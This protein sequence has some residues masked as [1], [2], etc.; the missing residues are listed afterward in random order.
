MPV[1]SLRVRLYFLMNFDLEHSEV[2]QVTRG[3]YRK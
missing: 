1:D 3:A 2:L